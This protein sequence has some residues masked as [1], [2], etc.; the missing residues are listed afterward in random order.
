MNKKFHLSNSKSEYLLVPRHW[1]RQS[2][3]PAYRLWFN[4]W[5]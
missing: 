1:L 3:S 2:E 5:V 4:G